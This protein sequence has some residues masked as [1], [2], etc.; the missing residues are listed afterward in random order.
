MRMHAVVGGAALALGLSLAHAGDVD[1][2]VAYAREQLAAAGLKETSAAPGF[3]RFEGTVPR[4][5]V[6]TLSPRRPEAAQGTLVVRAAHA[7]G[8]GAWVM[9]ESALDFE[10]FAGLAER[11]AA[12]KAGLMEAPK[13]VAAAPRECPFARFLGKLMGRP[14]ADHGTMAPRRWR[15]LALG[16]ARELMQRVSEGGRLARSLAEGVFDRGLMEPG[17]RRGR[18]EG[19]GP[20]AE[21]QPVLGA[22][23]RVQGEGEG[24]P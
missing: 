16:P 10:S 5:T 20:G 1:R 6:V 8:Q 21:A 15:P 7:D 2:Q 19:Q 11:L 13:P 24:R 23:A 3:Y 22:A 17:L 14:P 9:R 12:L 4:H 18:I